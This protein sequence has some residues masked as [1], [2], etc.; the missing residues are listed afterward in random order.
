MGGGRKAGRFR[1]I[2]H[3]GFRASPLNGC[4]KHGLASALSYKFILPCQGPLVQD[5]F[6]C[7]LL[8]DPARVG[9]L[10]LKPVTR[11]LISSSSGAGTVAGM[12]P[13]IGNV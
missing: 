1:A 10:T 9:R 3:E 2:S 11:T 4:I 13:M 6:L 7:N 8:C 12:E 5:G